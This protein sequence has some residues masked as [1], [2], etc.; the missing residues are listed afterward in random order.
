MAEPM[1]STGI[2]VVLKVWGVVAILSIAVFFTW[3][4]VVM[5]RLPRSRSEWTVSLISTVFGSIA[6]GGFIVQKYSL[7]TWTDNI[8]GAC[9]IGGIYFIAGLPIW[10]IIRWTF[11]Y[12]NGREDANIFEVIKEVKSELSELKGDKE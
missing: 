7:H 1:S 2:A 6:G 11:N 3:L 4:V 12:I 9:A 5:T 8:Y 10:A